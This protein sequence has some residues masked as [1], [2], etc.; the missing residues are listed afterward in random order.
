MPEF[1]PGV[2]LACI[3]KE[4]F[5]TFLGYD[6]SRAGIIVDHNLGPFRPHLYGVAFFAFWF[7]ALFL[8]D[9]TAVNKIDDRAWAER[10]E[11]VCAPVKLDVRRL[12]L[13]RTADLDGRAV[14]VVRSTDMLS[15]MLDELEAV[16]PADEKGQEI[17]PEWIADYRTLL[18]D[19]YAYADKLRAGEN[20]PFTETP[21]Q[22]VPIT[23]RIETFAGDNEMP[24]CAPPRSGV[25]G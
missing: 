17:V 25:L 20:V 21:V 19:R 8:I 6:F 18:D 16:E 5:R 22:G 2:M 23:E 3:S 9:K 4:T 10:A 24:S 15:A 1:K 11:E 12:D 7:W 13:E 14:L